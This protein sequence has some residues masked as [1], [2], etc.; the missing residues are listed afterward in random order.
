MAVNTCGELPIGP[1]V[2]PPV[3]EYIVPNMG[4]PPPMCRAS[5]VLLRYFHLC[6]EGDSAEATGY[7]IIAICEGKA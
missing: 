5:L 3:L 1:S 2:L 7:Y 6:S 4:Q